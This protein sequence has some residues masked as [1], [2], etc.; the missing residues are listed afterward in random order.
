MSINWDQ[1]WLTKQQT[2]VSRGP[3]A[4]H[5]NRWLRKVIAQYE[6]R[7]S[8]A[9]I[10]CGNGDTL[11]VLRPFFKRLAA[12]DNSLIAIDLARTRFGDV[13]F[14]RADICQDIGMFRQTFDLVTCVNALEE[15]SDDKVVLANFNRLLNS[16]GHLLLIT[17]HSKRYWSKQ[18]AHAGNLRRYELSEINEKLEAADFSI[19][20]SK[21]WGFPLYTLYYRLVLNRSN[22]SQQWGA[23]PKRTSIVSSVLYWILFIDDLFVRFNRGRILF[24]LARKK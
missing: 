18:D 13:E 12:L 2:N 4:R 23:A 3:S 22:P 21:T 17:Q 1:L 8:A 10:G 16:G 20:E 15:F 11:G 19:I 24:V 14:H 6:L 7:G 5:K 9:D